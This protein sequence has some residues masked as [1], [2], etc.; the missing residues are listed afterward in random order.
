MSWK[1][2]LLLF[3]WGRR[4]SPVKAASVTDRFAM[5]ALLDHPAWKILMEELDRE[6]KLAENRLLRQLQPPSLRELDQ[7]R[8]FLMG[9]AWFD[10]HVQAIRAI[11][12]RKDKE[13]AAPESDMRQ[14]SI[15]RFEWVGQ[16]P[17]E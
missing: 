9:L 5:I 10:L 1:T 6:A 3:F 15:H 8:G 16:P 14:P 13:Q 17:E 2:R 11:C 7:L 4:R 12:Q